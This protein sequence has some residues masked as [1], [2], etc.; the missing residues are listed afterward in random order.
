MDINSPEINAARATTI[1]PVVREI[2]RLKRRII[3]SERAGEDQGRRIAFL[4]RV[5]DRFGS[6]VFAHT[7]CNAEA[8]VSGCATGSCC[9]CRPDVFAWEKA[10]L[11][12][13]P[14]RQDN[15][16]FCPF[17]NSARRNCGIYGM[18]PFA[19]RIYYNVVSSR[20]SCQN[21][22]DSMLRL[23]ETLKPHLEK[24]IGPYQGGYGG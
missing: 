14:K 10:L 17:F 5:A 22:A 12:L 6:R 9:K 24:V 21:P 3:W 20:H 15:G 19:C 13:L 18:R 1:P 16:G 7:F 23:F 4:Y 11:D 8:A 2:E